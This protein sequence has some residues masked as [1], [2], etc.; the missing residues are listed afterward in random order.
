MIEIE[1]MKKSDLLKRKV[2]DY[3]IAKG[4]KASSLVRKMGGAGG[5]TAKNLALAADALEGMLKDRQCTRILSFPADIV[6]T[7]LRGVLAQAVPHF[8]AIITTCGTLDH[9]LARAWGKGYFH[10][11]FEMDDRALHHLGVNRLGNVLVPNESYGEILENK[12]Q[13]ILRELAGQ[14]PDWGGRE[15][16]AEFGKRVKDEGSILYQAYKHNVP[17]YVPGIT[18]G[19]FGTQLMMFAQDKKFSLNLLRDEK[20]LSD[21]VF[22]SKRLGALM[23]GG[24]ISKHHVIWWSQ[25]KG[26]LDYAVYITTATQYDGS[27]SGARL[28]EAISWG[29][30]KERARMATVDGDVTVILPLLLAAVYDRL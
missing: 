9:D 21:F 23:M 25:F 19:A 11:S 17:V 18:D 27:L 5:F 22:D 3:A 28:E 20:E 15:L 13:P 6:S 14:K 29:K 12:M 7:G 4:E 30:I 8:N 2:A 16:I 1:K 24:G 10:G 26:G